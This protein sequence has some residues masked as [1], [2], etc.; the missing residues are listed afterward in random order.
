MRMGLGSLDKS[1]V[2]KLKERFPDDEFSSEWTI[3]SARVL[4]PLVFPSLQSF[5][6]DW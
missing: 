2:S 1:A 6:V 5:L 4:T 3:A